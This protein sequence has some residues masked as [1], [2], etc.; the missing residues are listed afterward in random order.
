VEWIYANA[1]KPAVVNFSYNLEGDATG[2]NGSVGTTFR[3]LVAQRGILVVNSAGNSNTEAGN[4]VPTCLPELLVV[5]A[6]GNTDQG[7][8]NHFDANRRLQEVALSL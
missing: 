2:C 4:Y 6:I 3:N 1:V 8:P 7:N 5:G